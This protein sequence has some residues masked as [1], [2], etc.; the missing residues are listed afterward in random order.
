MKNWYNEFISALKMLEVEEVFDLLFYRPLAFLLVKII[1]PTS[2]TPNQ[3]TVAAVILGIIGGIYFSFG[4]PEYFAIA[5]ILFVF[6][7]VFDCS[8]GQLARLKKNGT[9]LG[10]ILDG[11]ADYIATTAAYIGIGIGLTKYTGDATTSWLLTIGAGITSAILSILLDFYRNRFLDVVLKRPSVLESELHELK[12]E[13]ERLKNVEGKLFEKWIIK[14]YLQYSEF[15]IK[16]ASNKKNETKT[17]INSELF[18]KKNKLIMHLWT[19]IGPTTQ[20]TFMIICS[21]FNSLYTYLI[22]LIIFGNIFAL[23]LFIWQKQIDNSLN[24]KG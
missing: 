3:L 9:K 24:L 10:R 1:Y 17:K 20:L 7:D 21:F 8:D 16:M 2:I 19:Y 18:Y 5:G 6:Y 15:Q 23:I 14:I 4:K 11:V 12:K 13:N 22:G